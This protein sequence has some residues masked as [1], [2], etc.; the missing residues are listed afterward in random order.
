VHTFLHAA[1]ALGDP[2]RIRIL[3]ALRDRELCVCQITELLGH[4]PSTVSRHMAVLKHA[5]LVESRKDGRWIYYRR[6]G[7]DAP[8]PVREALAWLD[9]SFNGDPD[10]LEDE[11]RLERIL[12]VTPE[13]LCRINATN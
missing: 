6:S 7:A 12:S 1:K 8:G 10:R 11:A 5:Q 4:A 2:S 3:L 9:G 13:E